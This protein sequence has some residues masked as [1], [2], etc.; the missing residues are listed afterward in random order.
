MCNAVVW[1]IEVTTLL[2]DVIDWPLPKKIPV[3]ATGSQYSVLFHCAVF[4][5]CH[6]VPI[7]CDAILLKRYFIGHSV[8]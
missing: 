4:F 3:C 2:D 1:F 5:P 8:N 6:T 7:V